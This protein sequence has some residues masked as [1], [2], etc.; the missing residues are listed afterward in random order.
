MARGWIEHNPPSLT[1]VVAGVLGAA[2]TL[3]ALVGGAWWLVQTFSGDLPDPLAIHWGADGQ[4]DGTATLEGTV[5]VTTGLGIAGVAVLLVAGLALVNR[6]RLLRGTITG[7]AA[8]GAL[9][10]ASLLLTVLPNLGQPTWETARISGWQLSLA[11]V[12]PAAVALVAWAAAARPPR[13]SAL[14]PAIPDGAPVAVDRHAVRETQTVGWVLGLAVAV[15][16][17]FGVL[18]ATTD[19]SLL[20]IG[21]LLGLLVAWLSVYRYEVDDDG[22]TVTFGPVGPLRRV[23]AVGEIEGAD[24]VTVR[25]REWGGWGYR[26]DGTSWAVVLR[27]GSGVRLALAGNR[28]LTLSSAA[29]ESIAGRTNGAVA[30]YWQR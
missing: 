5:R 20:G 29:P 26:T 15:L 21:V 10:P 13:T 9:A 27:S 2:V 30:R 22:L 8:L 28:A 17:G 1:R 12:I 14:G 4:A 7:V 23:V 18:G 16:V 19:P 6:P 3:L 25:P 11:L 24:V